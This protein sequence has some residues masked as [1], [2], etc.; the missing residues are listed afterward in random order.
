MFSTL[1]FLF[2]RDRHQGLPNLGLN[3]FYPIVELGKRVKFTKQEDGFQLGCAII[4]NHG[5]NLGL[6]DGYLRSGYHDP[7]PIGKIKEVFVRTHLLIGKVEWHWSLTCEVVEM[8]NESLSRD[9]KY[10]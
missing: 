10:G 4:N 3:N 2:A 6:R 8:R 1:G 7:P 9:I 5:H